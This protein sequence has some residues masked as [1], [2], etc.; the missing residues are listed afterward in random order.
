MSEVRVVALAPNRW[1]RSAIPDRLSMKAAKSLFSFEVRK[2][3]LPMLLVTSESL[4][5]RPVRRTM[6][7]MSISAASRRP[8]LLRVGLACLNQETSS[9]SGNGQPMLSAEAPSR[10]TYRGGKSSL[11]TWRKS[12]DRGWP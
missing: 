9:S 8:G 6:A 12:A 11:A 7:V 10:A 1:L 3:R 4:S 5:I 2:T